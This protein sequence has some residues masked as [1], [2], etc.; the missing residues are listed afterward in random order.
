VTDDRILR[1]V[2]GRTYTWALPQTIAVGNS[3]VDRPRLSTE[4]NAILQLA[5]RQDLSI[6]ASF[7]AP[8]TGD[9]RAPVS[10]VSA[11]NMDFRDTAL[12]TNSGGSA[13]VAWVQVAGASQ[14]GIY[15][16]VHPPLLQGRVWMPLVLHD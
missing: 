9:W 10:V 14:T 12:A 5:W 1:Y 8:H 15:E 6:R 16:S 2:Y 11:P 7:A 13:S 3:A 4:R